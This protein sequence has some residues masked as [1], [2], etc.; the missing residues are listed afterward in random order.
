ME[1]RIQYARA[2]DGVTIAFST[3]GQGM[4]VV[5]LPYM[6]FSHVQLEWQITP[7]REWIEHLAGKR[8]GL[9]WYDGRGMGCR[10]A[11]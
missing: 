7:S 4:P 5:R 6:P 1:P 2:A 11:R 9:V 3:I 10:N 8:R